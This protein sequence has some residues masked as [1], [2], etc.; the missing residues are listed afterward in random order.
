MV[1][2]VSFGKVIDC[3][4]CIEASLRICQIIFS[5]P[6]FVYEFQLKLSP[7]YF[8][9]F[10]G[11]PVR[12]HFLDLRDF[13][14]R[15]VKRGLIPL[16]LSQRKIRTFLCFIRCIQQFNFQSVGIEWWTEFWSKFISSLLRGVGKILCIFKIKISI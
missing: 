11:C 3:Y 13:N 10:F 1:F 16:L 2:T 15:L 14:S 12:F 9:K 4:I 5:F 8:K 7:F 6:P